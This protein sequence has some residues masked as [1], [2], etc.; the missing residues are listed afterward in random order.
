MTGSMRLGGRD[1]QLADARG[2]VLN[3]VAERDNVVPLPAPSSPVM[4]SSATPR[5]ARSCGCP[6]ATSPSATGRQRGQAHDAALAEWIIGAQRRTAPTRRSVMEIRPHRARR[7]RGA[8]AASSSGSRRP[9]ARSSRRTSTTRPWSPPG[10]VPARRGRSPSTTARW[11]APSQSCRCTAGRA[12]SARCAWS[13]T[14]AQRGRGIGRALARRAVVEAL[15]LGLTKL[16][17]EVIADQKPLIGM[18]RAARLRARGAARRPR[19]RPLRRD[20]RPHA[21][22]RTP[23]TRRW[24]PPDDRR[25]PSEL[26]SGRL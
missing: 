24:R 5:G 4:R 20:A 2:D 6:A 25:S 3:A 12:M 21:R 19:A 9:T 26:T 22:S 16:V 11:S 18:F 23:S 17:V 15:D 14:P 13:S 7:R 10:R 8:R 1:V